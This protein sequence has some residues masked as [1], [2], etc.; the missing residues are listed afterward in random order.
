MI[1]VLNSDTREYFVVNDEIEA[2]Y[3]KTSVVK[4]IEENDIIYIESKKL[5]KR[6]FSKK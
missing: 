1:A 5:G 2:I 3:K 6:L 4:K